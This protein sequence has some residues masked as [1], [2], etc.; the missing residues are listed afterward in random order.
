VSKVA[1]EAGD[2]QR[3]AFEKSEMAGKFFAETAGIRIPR[4]LEKLI[5]SSKGVSSA[6]AAAFEVSVVAIFAKEVIELIPEIGKAALEFG[7][8][9][10]AAQ[11]AYEAAKKANMERLGGGTNLTIARQNISYINQQLQK[12]ED[13]RDTV[14]EEW[15]FF[16]HIGD[17]LGKIVGYSTDQVKRETLI[18]DLKQ[19]QLLAME[20][21]GKLEQES[22]ARQMQLA[23]AAGAAGL[24]G[25]ASIAQEK[26]SAINMLQQAMG[27][28]KI[29]P[30]EFANSVALVTLKAQ[31]D[32]ADLAATARS[33]TQQM[34]LQVAQIG[35]PAI[36]AAHVNA[37]AE[38]A[39]INAL[40]ERSEIS[41]DE[42]R[43]RRALIRA[44][45]ERQAAL[46]RMEME[47]KTADAI[48][49]TQS[50]GAK[51]E[52]AIRMELQATLA[53]VARDEAKSGFILSD[54][55]VAAED[56]ADKKIAEMRRQNSE[57]IASA[58]QRAT[59]AIVPEWQRANLQIAYDHANQVR[60]IRQQLSDKVLNQ[61]EADRMILDADAEM[62]GRMIDQHRQMV[63]Q[64]GD[65]MDQFAQDIG[66]GN[67]GKRILE[68]FRKLTLMMVAQYVS[69]FTSMKSGTPN[70]LMG[71][72][73]G[74]N[75]LNSAATS[76]M[77]GAAAGT[78]MMMSPAGGGAQM[79]AALPGLAMMGGGGGSSLFG[80]GAGFSGVGSMSGGA[81][82]SGP[83]FTAENVPIGGGLTPAMMSTLTPGG[84][85]GSVGSFLG[86][87]GIRS[88]FTGK[89]LTGLAKGLSPMLA[90]LVGGK[91]GGTTGMLGATVLAS[92]LTTSAGP[93]GVAMLS[94]LLGTSTAVAGG[95]LAGAGGGL[96]G[97][98]LGQNYG[99]TAGALSGAASGALT[100]LA[101]GPVGALIGGLIGLV[102]GLFGGIFGG[103]KRK[104]QA[105]SIG[106]QVELDMK[107]LVDEYKG[108]QI[109]YSSALS[110][111]DQLKS[112]SFDALNKLKG[113]GKSV[114]SKR[115]L[116]DFDNTRKQIENIETERQRRSGLVFSPPMFHEGGQYFSSMGMMGSFRTGSGEGLALL[117]D[118][119]FIVNPA[120]TRKNLPALQRINAGGSAGGDTFHI[121]AIDAKSFRTFLRDGGVAEIKSA[122]VSA[123]A[124]GR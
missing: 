60:A 46:A 103:S 32:M 113:E 106:D 23:N 86:G 4:Q 16:Q 118:R 12:T 56:L 9:S 74:G 59:L 66:S 30:E 124:E 48:L 18:S 96:L 71:L 98:G 54:Q 8:F 64:L 10:A 91:L 11:Q 42:A 82:A 102:G 58:D 105:N 107:K 90:G 104:R 70:L 85:S 77:G 68:N 100:G 78:G 114:Y 123:R 76:M 37:I 89:G 14:E 87:T 94:N 80:V 88:L 15:G 55:R 27:A 101:F 75:Y 108:H 62:N 1:R 29:S 50:Y 116:P 65:A 73:F 41:A 5:S 61:Q 119:E 79:M 47:Q 111:L 52:T 109:D 45:E 92:L 83:G 33:E 99:K 26:S 44:Q 112:D 36:V 43:R 25:F 13:I 24:H 72:L 6:L 117:R 2:E 22:L 28:Q 20:T 31:R 35:M 57:Q 19:Q 115:L 39:K 3:K 63:Q 95:L 122:F 49:K 67:V 21:Q 121:T 51:G 17:S 110:Q 120:A 7:G 97:F 40:E 34:V 53:Q 81:G 69:S 38:I 93:M 84:G